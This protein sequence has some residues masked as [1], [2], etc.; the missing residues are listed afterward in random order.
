[1]SYLFGFFLSIV[2]IPVLLALL[3]LLVVAV[4]VKID[5]IFKKK[6]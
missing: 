1:M 2:G 4:S 5:K 3:G 6:P